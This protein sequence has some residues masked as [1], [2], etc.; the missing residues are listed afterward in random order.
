MS[1]NNG[2]WSIKKLKDNLILL[3]NR[4]FNKDFINHFYNKILHA[5]Y[6]KHTKY[7]THIIHV[8]YIKYI[9]HI[10]HIRHHQFH[11]HCQ[12]RKYLQ[13]RQHRQ[14]SKHPKYPLPI[15]TWYNRCDTSPLWH[16]FTDLNFNLSFL[17]FNLSIFRLAFPFLN[18][19]HPGNLL[20]SYKIITN[21][22]FIYN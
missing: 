14:H 21:N 13:H 3:L 22:V 8:K 9:K 18:D 19:R 1:N 12:H 6:V 7:I 11:Q 16:W 17:K 15:V 2:L 10:K 5:I 20:V 4:F